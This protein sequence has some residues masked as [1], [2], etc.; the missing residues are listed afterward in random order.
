[1]KVTTTLYNI[2]QIISVVTRKCSTIF[3]GA[4][5][6]RRQ[7]RPG[8]SVS[9]YIAALHEIAAKCEFL[10]AQLNERVRDQCV[11]WYTSDRIRERYCWRFRCAKSGLV[12]MSNSSAMLVMW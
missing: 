10:A 9:Q 2:S 7:Q 3:T 4:Q 6:T 1:V 8:E 5:F 11:A 12:T